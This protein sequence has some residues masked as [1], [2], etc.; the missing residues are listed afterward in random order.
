MNI[1]DIQIEFKENISRKN[2]LKTEENCKEN[3]E[4][5]EKTKDAYHIT[6]PN[7]VDSQRIV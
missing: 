4:A 1:N 7:F 5:I 2:T 3:S 6:N